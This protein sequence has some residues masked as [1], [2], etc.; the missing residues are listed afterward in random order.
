[1]RP[2]VRDRLLFSL[3]GVLCLTLSAYAG[4]RRAENGIPD[5]AA[6]DALLHGDTSLLTGGAAETWRFCWESGGLEYGFQDLDGD[7]GDEL[8]VQLEDCP[9]GMNAVFHYNGQSIDCWELD[10]VEMT[11]WSEPL[12]D[13]TMA[14]LYF[15]GGCRNYRIFRYGP[16]GSEHETHVL[17]ARDELIY[18]EDRSPC[19][20]YEIDGREVT[21][22]EFDRFLRQEFSEKQWQRGDWAPV[23]ADPVS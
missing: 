7:G 10:A 21:A 2:A 23:P 8:L 3:I 15:Y 17:F 1:M 9:A 4:Q 19:P 12:S 18:P 5:S 11:G 13:G 20:Y 22:D 16:D 14:R 6:Y